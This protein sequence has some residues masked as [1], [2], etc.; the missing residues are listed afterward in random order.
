MNTKNAKVRGSVVAI[1]AVAGLGL[2]SLT[3]CSTA[4]TS[5]SG[6]G[7]I[8]GDGRNGH[9]ANIHKVVLPG[10]NVGFDDSS[11]DTQYVP[12][13]GRNYKVAPDSKDAGGATPLLARTSDNTEVRVDLVAYW[14]LNQNQDVLR[15]F[16]DFATKYEDLFSSS[17]VAGGDNNSTAGWNSMLEENL[18]PTLNRATSAAM[19]EIGDDIWRKDDPQ[20]KEKLSRLISERFRDEVRTVTGFSEDLFCGSGN[21]EWNADH[22]KFECTNVRVAVDMVVASNNEQQQVA[23]QQTAAAARVGLARELYG[24]LA[25]QVM[26]CQDLKTATCVIG[27]TSVQVVPK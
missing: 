23:Q 7:F 8:V 26:A 17:P 14:T 10:E 4:A 3:G 6:C 22:T 24:P 27:G 18:R 25:E 16:H 1:A 2:L 19:R 13:S 21:S 15:R 9:D 20:L 12:C 11:E 5:T